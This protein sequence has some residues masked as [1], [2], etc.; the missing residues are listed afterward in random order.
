MN[1]A[2]A[3]AHVQITA[4]RI[5]QGGVVLHGAMLQVDGLQDWAPLVVAD[6]GGGSWYL[7]KCV[8]QGESWAARYEYR[9]DSPELEYCI[10]LGGRGRWENLAGTLSTDLN[11]LTV[12]V[13]QLNRDRQSSLVGDLDRRDPYFR[14][15]LIGV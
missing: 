4:R 5:L 10:Q 11:D 6:P 13:D 12:Q 3:V 15:H 14:T 1:P 2:S 7:I 8:E 9:V